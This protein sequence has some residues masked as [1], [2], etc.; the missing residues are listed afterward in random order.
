MKKQKKKIPKLKK[1]IIAKINLSKVVGGSALPYR[2]ENQDT[3]SNLP[4]C[5]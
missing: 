5:I 1:E 4:G 3:P 2:T